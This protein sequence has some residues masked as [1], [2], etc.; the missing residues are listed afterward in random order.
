MPYKRKFKGKS[1]HRQ[2]SS[3]DDEEEDA[4]HKRRSKHHQESSDDEEEDTRHKS[5]SFGKK[6]SHENTKKLF[7]KKRRNGGDHKR[8]FVVNKNEWVTDVSSSEDSSDEENIFGLAITKD[9]QPLPPP[10]MCLMA[11]GK[12]KVC[13]EEIDPNA[14]SNL[15]LEF[16]QMIEKEKAKFKVLAGVHAKLKGSHLA[17]VDKYNELLHKHNDTV[18]LADQVEANYVNLKV[19]HRELTYKY[20]ELEYAYK[21]IGRT[22]DKSIVKEVNAPTSYE[23]LLMS[24]LATNALPKIVASREK[25]LMDQVASL[26]TSVEKLSRGEL[27]H[28]EVLFYNA[29]DYG[30]RGFG[31]FPEPNKATTPSLKI[32]T[33]FIKEVGSYCQH[34]QVTGHH[35]RKCALPTCPLLNLPKSYSS[36][37]A[38]NHFLL[39]KVKGK[40]K[41]KFIGKLTREARRKLPKQLWIPKALVTHV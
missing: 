25:E 27:K 39:S 26:K 5:K 2:D 31:L 7:P 8:S 18:A 35:T 3:C 29:H 6:K 12:D 21:A 9:D 33:S 22:L 37:N 20:Q 28:K 30:K 4:K 1:K 40:V 15:I 34:C 10:P 17:L 32:K 41:A 23:D 16:T 38:S 36:T 13:Q 24:N 14:F 19:E 11:Q